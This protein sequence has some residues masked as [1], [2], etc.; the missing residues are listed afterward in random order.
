MTTITT[1]TITTTTGEIPPKRG[2]AGQ[3][4]KSELGPD[5]G[6]NLELGPQMY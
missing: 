1:T 3:M 2:P 5:G 6:F 4:F